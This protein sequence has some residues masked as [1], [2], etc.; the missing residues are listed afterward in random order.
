[1]KKLPKP[2]HR[3]G[4]PSSQLNKILKDLKIDESLFRVAFGINTVSVDTK[5]NETIYYMCDV[6]RALLE[7]KHRFGKHHLWD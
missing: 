2:K 5:T 1:M 6:E 7:L 3:L 4:Y